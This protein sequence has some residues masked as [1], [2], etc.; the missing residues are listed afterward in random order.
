[1]QLQIAG[2][3]NALFNFYSLLIIIW[4][5]LSWFP[6]GNGGMLDDVRG[7]LETVV[8]PYMNIFRKF[9]P[10]LGGID[11]SPILAI[12]VLEVVQR[13]ILGILL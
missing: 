6:R 12:V 7:V 1:M 3:I 11:F 2:A 8:G 4:C 10:P 13:L 9:I 5:I